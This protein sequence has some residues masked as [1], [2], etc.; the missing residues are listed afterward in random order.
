M[1]FANF[2]I[3]LACYKAIE[4]TSFVPSHTLDATYFVP[5]QADFTNP[6]KACFDAY[7]VP[8]KKSIATI[9]NKTHIH[10]GQVF[11]GSKIAALVL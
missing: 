7:I 4:A 9:Q 11:L 10:Q 3:S 6:R 5:C 2:P 1:S 8:D